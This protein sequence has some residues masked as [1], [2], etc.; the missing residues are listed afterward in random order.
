MFSLPC[1]EERINGAYA[2]TGNALTKRHSQL[3][4]NA[5]DVNAS[6]DAILALQKKEL[7]QTLVQLLTCRE[8]LNVTTS[9]TKDILHEA[10]EQD[11]KSG[12]VV[13]M[14]RQLKSIMTELERLDLHRDMRSVAEND[15]IEFEEGDFLKKMKKKLDAGGI[16]DKILKSEMDGDPDIVAV[17][18]GLRRCV[19]GDETSVSG[20]ATRETERCKKYHPLFQDIH[21]SIYV[22]I[23]DT[24]HDFERGGRE[25]RD[26]TGRRQTRG[27]SQTHIF[28]R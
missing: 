7:E 17:G 3:I 23:S 5:H 20:T 22:F 28:F 8:A 16:G 11:A 21:G 26:Q 14:C 19:V 25:S 15:K 13:V 12:D 4:E 2:E 6:K 10:T 18:E 27:I 1:A 9:L 24:H